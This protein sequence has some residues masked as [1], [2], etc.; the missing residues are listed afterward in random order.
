MLSGPFILPIK[1]RI[2]GG[3]PPG[4][5]FELVNLEV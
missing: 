5:P 1:Y 3:K 2:R 4:L